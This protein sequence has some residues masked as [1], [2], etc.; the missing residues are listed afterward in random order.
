MD[1]PKWPEAVPLTLWAL[2]LNRHPKEN[3][4]LNSPLTEAETDGNPSA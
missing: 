3:Q 1:M 2:T 4:N